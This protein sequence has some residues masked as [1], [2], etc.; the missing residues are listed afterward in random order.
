VEV[1]VWTNDGSLGEVSWSGQYRFA[2]EF[3]STGE[4]CYTVPEDVWARLKSETFYV[5]VQGANP[6]I[7]VT[8]GWWSTQWMGA[9]NDIKPGNE[10]LEDL[11]DG[12][13]RLTVNLEGDPLVNVID[14]EH[15]LFTGSG[16]SVQE[17]YFVDVVPGG[18]GGGGP[19]EVVL[20]QGDGSAGAVSWSGQYRFGLEGKDGNNECIA[21]FP[22]D[23]WNRIKTGTFYMQYTADDPSSYQIR[24]T[25]GWW[26]VQWMGADNDIAPWNM[27]ERIIDNG[28]GTF[29]IEV[30]FGDDPI[31]GSLDDQHLLFTGSG[32]TPM[33][34]YYYE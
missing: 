18:G 11:G 17:I 9:D 12:I 2:P 34:L 29:Y 5:T 13:W 28:D 23:V 10:L 8:S 16:Y 4:E 30:N 33:K 3:N 31:V 21:T 25:T 1:P 15:L 14:A 6:Q 7:R 26:S 32:Y 22:E 27:A 24:V 19:K 20:W